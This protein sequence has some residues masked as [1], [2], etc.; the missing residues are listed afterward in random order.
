VGHQRGRVGKDQ[1]SPTEE[2]VESQHGSKKKNKVQ[3]AWHRDALP[4]IRSSVAD[5]AQK[6]VHEGRLAIC[7]R[8]G[9]I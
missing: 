2:D 6:K 9:G 4:H 5:S 7:E 1:R 8:R 3:R